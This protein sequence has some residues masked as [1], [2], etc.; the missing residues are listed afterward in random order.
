MN[1]EIPDELKR[2]EYKSFVRVKVQ[3]AADGAFTVVLRTSSGNQ[4]SI[5]ECSPR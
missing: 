1:P 3:I 2:Q 4:E 5:A